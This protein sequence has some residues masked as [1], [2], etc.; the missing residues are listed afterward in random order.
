MF[1]ISVVLYQ[2]NQEF[3]IGNA[4]MPI[5]DLCDLVTD[6]E[7][8]KNQYVKKSDTSCLKRVIFLYG[9]SYSQRENCIIGKVQ[10]E[11][12]YGMIRQI[13]TKRESA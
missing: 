6:Y 3:V 1:N 11:V 8:C 2:N 10:I 4:Q 9:T 7:E 13:L 5:E 12:S